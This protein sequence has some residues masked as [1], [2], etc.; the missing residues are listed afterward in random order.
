M[1]FWR[2]PA[3]MPQDMRDKKVS[4][5]WQKCVSVSNLGGSG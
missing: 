1:G 2:L 5:L 4:D 3:N